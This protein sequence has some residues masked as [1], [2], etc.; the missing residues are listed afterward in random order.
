MIKDFS[1]MNYML[2][3]NRDIPEEIA[4]GLIGIWI[5]N[6]KKYFSQGD[7]QYYIYSF[8]N[9]DAGIIIRTKSINGKIVYD[10]FQTIVFSKAPIRCKII[11]INIEEERCTLSVNDNCLLVVA[12]DPMGH[13]EGD[14]ISVHLNFFAYKI[15]FSS[16]EREY[17]D[18]LIKTED[19]G[20]NIFNIG[21][22][23]LIPPIGLIKGEREHYPNI[24]EEMLGNFNDSFMVASGIID[25][26]YN[27]EPK[28]K[29]DR[30]T[31]LPNNE[32]PL[33]KCDCAE[34]KTK[35][36][37][38]PVIIEKEILAKSLLNQNIENFELSE[39]SI[40]KTYGYIGGFI[41][42]EK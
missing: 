21:V 42:I 22:G 27:I 26:Y 38:I 13:K 20:L 2:D 33:G 8:E 24:T 35:I 37:I 17:L 28:L 10:D 23:E 14:E 3:E 30:E 31:D 40:I 9:T 36:G 29:M 4:N 41:D 25:N 1:F 34:M 15:E 12:M 7:N 16:N 39:T 18:N 19:G 32:L 11:G 5:E 6:A